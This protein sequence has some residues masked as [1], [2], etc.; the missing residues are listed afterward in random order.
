MR[1]LMRQVGQLPK[2]DLARM[3]R[4]EAHSVQRCATAVEGLAL[5]RSSPPVAPICIWVRLIIGPNVSSD[6]TTN[7]AAVQPGLFK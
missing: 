1:E 5:G 4:V 3:F 2:S 7:S 6:V